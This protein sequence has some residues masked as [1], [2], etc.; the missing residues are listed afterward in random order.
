MEANEQNLIKIQKLLDA[1]DSESFT[2]KNFLVAFENVVK[3]VLEIEKRNLQEIEALKTAYTQVADK[4]QGD[5]TTSLSD[6]RQ[7]VDDSFIGEKVKEIINN[8][9]QQKL[10]EVDAKSAA[11]KDGPQ[12]MQGLKGDKGDKGSPDNPIEIRDKLELLQGKAR[13]SKDAIDGLEELEKNLTDRIQRVAQ[14]RTGLG[15]GGVGK[16]ALDAHF[17]DDETPAGSGVTFTLANTPNP[18][19]SLKLYRG[20]ARQR[21]TEDYTLSEKI[22]T[23][24]VALAT[25]EILLADYKI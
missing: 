24:N 14:G 7:Q 10:N 13:L 19:S 18:T 12:G 17:I 2:K 6:L 1:M 9:I 5:H 11:L 3:K 25:N 15:G 16:L 4:L 22:I 8:H 23:L 20:G 21:I